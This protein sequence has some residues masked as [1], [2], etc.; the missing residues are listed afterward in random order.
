MLQMKIKAGRRTVVPGDLPSILGAQR[1]YREIGD[2][3]DALIAQMDMLAGDCE[4]EDGDDDHCAAGDDTGSALRVTQHHDPRDDDDCETS[5]AEWHTLHPSRRSAGAIDGR[6]LNE[7]E[8]GHDDDEDDG[9]LEGNGDEQDG[10]MA[11][12]DFMLHAGSGPGCDL[13][14]PGGLG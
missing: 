10:N 11:E 12:D 14:D 4:M 3:V 8:A 9:T 7:W 13:S 5:Y 6:M 1:A 2:M